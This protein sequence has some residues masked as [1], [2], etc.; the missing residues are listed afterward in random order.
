MSIEI[1]NNMLGK[2]MSEV[3]VNDSNDEMI[4]KS[5]DGKT[6]KFYHSQDCCESVLIEDISGDINDLVGSPIL[7]AEEIDNLDHPELEY[8]DDYCKWTFYKFGTEKGFVTVRWFGSSNGYYG[9]DV[10]YTEE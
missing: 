2:V 6:F 5:D 9:V 7:M 10:N 8:A 3:I 4:F 1:F